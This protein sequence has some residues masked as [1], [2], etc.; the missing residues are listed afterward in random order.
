MVEEGSVT[1][2][3]D[4]G[5]QVAP[6]AVA[7]KAGQF[8]LTLAELSVDQRRIAEK[9]RRTR[10]YLEGQEQRT[11]FVPNDRSVLSEGLKV[12]YNGVRL[13][14]PVGVPTSVPA[15]VATLVEERLAAAKNG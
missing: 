9:T 6:A 1:E 4:E 7:A 14:I 11:V 5:A 13:L 8:G 15:D 10:E 3:G 2:A 12:T